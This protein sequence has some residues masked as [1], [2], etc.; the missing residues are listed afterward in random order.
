MVLV[1]GGVALREL[2]AGVG[3]ARLA[4]RQRGHGDEPGERVRVV[5]ERVEV[6]RV[7]LQPGERPDRLAGLALGASIGSPAYGSGSPGAGSSS[8]FSAARRPKT[9]HSLSEFEASR[10]APCRPVQAHSPT[11]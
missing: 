11:A 1:E 3:A 7:A 9:K 4:A 5:R 2:G 6:L 8:A 10:L